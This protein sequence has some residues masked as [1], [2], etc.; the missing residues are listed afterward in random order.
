MN[1]F[2]FSLSLCLIVVTSCVAIGQDAKPILEAAA[3]AYANT[4][5]FAVQVDS[6][7][8]HLMFAPEVEGELPRYDVRATEFYRAQLR[9]KRPEAY[10]LAVQRNFEG[11]L[12]SSVGHNTAPNTWSVMGRAELGQ[13]KQGVHVGTR[14]LV[15]DMPSEQFNRLATT[16]LGAGLMEDMVLRHFRADGSLPE[17]T[18]PLG[19]VEGDVIGREHVDG[20]PA[21]RIAAKTLDGGPAIVWVD[22]QSSLIVRT[23]V[24][25]P[26]DEPQHLRR[27]TPGRRLMVVETVYKNQQAPAA[28]LSA[29]F[30]VGNP[31][32]AETLNAAKLG[33]VS[34]AELVKLADIAPGAQPAT[35]QAQATAAPPPEPIT[36]P[37][38]QEETPEAIVG[39]ALSY[40]QMSGI[41]LIDGEGGTATGFM[42]KIRDVDFVVTNLH[43]LV[44]NRKISI[45]T[46]RGEEVP[47]QG[48][49]GAVGGDIAIIRIPKGEGDLRLASDVFQ[50]SKI[51]DKVVVVGNRRGG[52]VATQTSGSIKGIGPKLIEVDANF[53]SGNSGSPIVNLATNEVVGV[54]TYSET[55]QVEVESTEAAQRPGMRR[56]TP[57]PVKV[58]KRWF[59]FRL[60][61]V[62]RWEAIDLGRWNAQAERIDK[63]RETSEAL[64]AVIKFDFASAR[65]HPRLTSI[66][67]NF[68]SR[69]RAAG[70]SSLNAATEVKDLFRVIRSIS[71][72][73]VREL[74]TG[75]YYDYYRTCDYWENSIPSQLDYR[76]RIV[77]VLKKYESNSSLYLSRMRSGER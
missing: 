3:K 14:Y 57:P 43:V 74:T 62:S 38:A 55:R 2:R 50:T 19:L 15:Q 34:V 60:D 31:P 68:E 18:I 59:G 27:P 11:T 58:D 17:G 37:P 46:L 23:I 77:E 70:K 36:A 12:S 10:W 64:V 6:R 4:P 13:A 51:G 44:G 24:Q 42:T 61:G 53:Q 76:K 40:E 9:V 32:P 8:L 65:Q 5:S 30:L 7:T 41:V 69:Y 25:R 66:I 56:V 39:Q 16:R 22:Q 45:K 1:L 33:F 52:G 49:F 75:D 28:F 71:E 21:Y 26:V 67:D 35:T 48:I 47:V 72:D 54:A 73:G 20:R 29:D 63:F